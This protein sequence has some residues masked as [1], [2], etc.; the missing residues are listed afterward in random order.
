MSRAKSLPLSLPPGVQRASE[1]ILFWGNVGFWVQLVLGVIAAVILLFASTGVL[2]QDQQ[3]TPAN[4]FGL[5]CAAG[6]LIALVISIVC[7]FRC[8]KIAQLMRSPDGAL[9]PK[10][11]YTIQ[12]IKFGLIANLSGMFLSIVGAEALVGLVLAK[13]LNLPQGTNTPQ[14]SP[15]K[16]L[17]AGEIISILA[18]THT[19]ACHFFGVVIALWL[20]N[21]LNR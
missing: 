1:L 12:V 18:N 21:R 7:F 3:A 6:G 11:S 17:K 13:F 5:V 19:I 10:K 9:R 14:I 15:D 2:I 8:R 16:L 4:S 20:L